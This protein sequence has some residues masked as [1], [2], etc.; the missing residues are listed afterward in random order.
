[1]ANVSVDPPLFTASIGAANTYILRPAGHG[2]V[3]RWRISLVSSSFVGSLTVKARAAGST[4]TFRAVPYIKLHL[5]AAVG[6]A[7]QVSTAIT[8][9]SLIEVDSTGMDVAVDCTSYTSG[10]MALD[11]RPVLG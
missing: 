4:D 8:D 5:N 6:D 7:S 2:V 11:A 1:M 10:T 9:S 3:S